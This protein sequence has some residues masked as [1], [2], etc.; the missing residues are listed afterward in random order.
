M[1][2]A[3]VVLC[4]LLT[5]SISS[6]VRAHWTVQ[7]PSF[8]VQLE[9]VYLSDYHCGPQCRDEIINVYHSSVNKTDVLIGIKVKGDEWV[10][11]GE[12]TFIADAASRQAF[13]T[14]ARSSFIDPE[15]TLLRIEVLNDTCFVI[16]ASEGTMNRPLYYY[17]MREFDPSRDRQ[18]TDMLLVASTSNKNGQRVPIIPSSP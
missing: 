18:L 8:P 16:E 13:V 3:I 14:A 1:S 12:V 7:P 15:H 6:L 2:K 17:K 10:P 9:G 4:F 11:A 5:T